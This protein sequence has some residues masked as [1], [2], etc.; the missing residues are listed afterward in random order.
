MKIDSRIYMPKAS[1]NDQVKKKSDISIDDFMKILAAE[2]SNQSI[3]GS[4]GGGGGSKT[5]YISQ[6]A[7]LTNLEQMSTIGENLN[8]LNFMGQH[9]YAFSLIGKNVSVINPDDP[10]NLEN[11]ITGLVDKVKFNQGYAVL[12]IDGK[13]YP[14]GLI[15]EVSN[16]SGDLSE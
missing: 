4:E 16:N 6:L 2:L 10:N 13:D 7:Q 8:T 5:D 14:V 15:L 3:V 9:Q 11:K 1:N 12:E